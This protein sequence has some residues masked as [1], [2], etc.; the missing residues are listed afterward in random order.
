MK[1]QWSL[2]VKWQTRRKSSPIRTYR[3][4]FKDK[5]TAG[6]GGAQMMSMTLGK[7]GLSQNKMRLKWISTDQKATFIDDSKL[8]N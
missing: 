6:Y 4:L 8:I 2:N 3:H 1:N 7:W 5:Y